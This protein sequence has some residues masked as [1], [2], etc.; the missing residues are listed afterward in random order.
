MF[1]VTLLFENDRKQSLLVRCCNFCSSPV[2]C[3]RITWHVCA[4]H[5]TRITNFAMCCV[6]AFI[7]VC[8][9]WPLDVDHVSKA[10]K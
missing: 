9:E 7:F 10:S 5:V 2:L 4:H 6:L 1:Y 3:V 8:F